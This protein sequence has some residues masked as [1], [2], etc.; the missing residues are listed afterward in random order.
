MKIYVCM[1]VNAEGVEI[2]YTA[3][4]LSYRQVV[5]YRSSPRCELVELCEATRYGGLPQ[6]CGGRYR[7]PTNP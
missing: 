5:T 1:P 4:G 2:E 7:D 6:C 3:S